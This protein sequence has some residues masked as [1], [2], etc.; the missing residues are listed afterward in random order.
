MSSPSLSQAD[1]LK[2]EGNALFAKKDFARASKK[3]TEALKHDGENAI[4]YSNRAACSLGLNRYGCVSTQACIDKLNDAHV[5]VSGCEYGR[6]EGE[7]TQ[8]TC[9]SHPHRLIRMAGHGY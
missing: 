7:Y 4:L 8:Y 5:K 9:V 2:A 6:H 3:Y 1:R